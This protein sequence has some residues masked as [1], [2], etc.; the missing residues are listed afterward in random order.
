M[1]VAVTG[2]GGF[3][4]WHVC[5]RLSAVG[6]HEVLPITRALFQDDQALQHAIEKADAVV[7]LAGINQRHS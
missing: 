1:K 4:G 3:L 6:G 7:H 5:A 2:A